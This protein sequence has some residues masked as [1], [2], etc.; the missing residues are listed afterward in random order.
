MNKDKSR[1]KE[2][3]KKPQ[4]TIKEKRA[5]KRMMKEDARKLAGNK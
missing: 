1:G 2:T 5:V 3:K 4:M